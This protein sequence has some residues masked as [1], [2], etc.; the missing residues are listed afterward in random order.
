MLACSITT[1]NSEHWIKS[2]KEAAAWLNLETHVQVT[3]WQEAVACC[4]PIQ[5]TGR[6]EGAGAWRR[7]G[8]QPDSTVEAVASHTH[9]L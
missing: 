5:L 1:L 6:I 7:P 8:L 3:D 2:M 4:T 9:D